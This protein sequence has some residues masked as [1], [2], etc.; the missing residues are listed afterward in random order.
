VCYTQEGMHFQAEQEKN[1]KSIDVTNNINK[2][3][4]YSQYSA[5]MI[6]NFVL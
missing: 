1:L 3:I 2:S 4:S 6:A 5:F